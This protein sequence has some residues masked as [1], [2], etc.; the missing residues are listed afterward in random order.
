MA[1]KKPAKKS[2]K[3]APARAVKARAGRA[4]PSQSQKNAFMPPKAQ[5]QKLRSLYPAIK[6]YNSGFLKVTDGHELYFEECGNPEGKP[7]L[8]VH[9]GPGV[10]S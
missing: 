6:P 9:G 2:A 1:K 3:K 4:A 8:M 7:A 10:R 5:A